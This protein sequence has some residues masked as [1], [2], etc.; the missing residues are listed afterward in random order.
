M[1]PMHNHNMGTAKHVILRIWI[2][3]GILDNSSL[4]KINQR[5]ASVIVPANVTFNSLPATIEHFSSFTAEQMMIWVNYYSLFCLFGILAEND[6]ECWRHFVLASR[7]L[8]KPLLTTDDILMADKLLLQFGRRFEVIYGKEAIT[9]N[10]HMHGHL[11]ECIFDYGPMSSFWLHQPTNN[12]SIEVQ[13]MNR[14]IQD[15]S[16]IHN[17][18]LT[19]N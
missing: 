2:K 12:R 8:S 13:L 11:A 19:M 7:L 6:Y 10:M 18:M 1:D 17:I 16:H 5:M 14:F 3:R 4:Q 15:N 9:P